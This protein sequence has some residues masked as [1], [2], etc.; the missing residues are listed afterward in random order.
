MV[1]SDQT[2]QAN[3]KYNRKSLLKKAHVYKSVIPPVKDSLGRF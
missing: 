2:R 3:D 1:G